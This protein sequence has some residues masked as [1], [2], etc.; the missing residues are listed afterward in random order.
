MR[1]GRNP[2]QSRGL[3][4]PPPRNE[5]TEEKKW[6]KEGGEEPAAKPRPDESAPPRKEMTEE[7]KREKGRGG[8]RGTPRPDEPALFFPSFSLSLYF[9]S[10]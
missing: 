2:R 3:T 9:V 6:K 8:T 7:K 4:T 5:M 10:C 1:A